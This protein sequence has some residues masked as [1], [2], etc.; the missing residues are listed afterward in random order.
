MAKVK[1][2]LSPGET[3]QE[4]EDS[5]LKAMNHHNNGDVHSETFQDPAMDSVADRMIDAHSKIYKEMLE[6]IFETLDQEY[7]KKW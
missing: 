3:L 7:S 5:L 6:E 2:F 4:A 1:I